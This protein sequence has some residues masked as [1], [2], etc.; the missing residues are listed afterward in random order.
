MK[1]AIQ[2]EDLI[3]ELRRSAVE[4][5]QMVGAQ[6]ADKLVD[7]LSTPV[8]RDAS[9][10][11]VERSKPNEDPRMETGE[12]REGV[13]VID[14]AEKDLAVDIRVTREGSFKIPVILQY[15]EGYVLDRPFMTHSQQ[16]DAPDAL[17]DIMPHM[18]GFKKR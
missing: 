7:R 10:N 8:G 3:A 9:G 11:V 18:V 16:V 15:G 13:Q 14:R 2:I 1:Q 5:L 12:L 6:V 4:A 17:N